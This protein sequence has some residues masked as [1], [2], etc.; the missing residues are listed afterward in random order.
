[1]QIFIDH[2]PF[3]IIIL[4]ETI[5]LSIISKIKLRDFFM[6]FGLAFMSVMAVRHV[7]FL[8]LLGIFYLVAYSG[9]ADFGSFDSGPL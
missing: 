2:S 7:S 3:T 5:V 1:M 6:I 4:V 8:A 9:N